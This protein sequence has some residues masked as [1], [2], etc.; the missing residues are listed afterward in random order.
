MVITPKH[1]SPIS[2]QRR[3]KL[4][5]SFLFFFVCVQPPKRRGG[6]SSGA[7][8][9][10]SGQKKGRRQSKLAKENDISA[11]EEAEIKEAFSL[12]ATEHE[13]YP[14]EKA[15][16]IPTPDVRRAMMYVVST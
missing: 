14:D 9:V 6:A 4:T 7:P 12:F 15:G 10:R 5:I 8:N 16:V 11:D 3:L 13:D 2:S 1:H